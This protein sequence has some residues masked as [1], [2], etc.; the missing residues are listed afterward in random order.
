M[1]RSRVNPGSVAGVCMFW[2]ALID[3]EQGVLG[4]RP[5]GFSFTNVMLYG[6]HVQCSKV[7]RLTTQA[8][9]WP[10]SQ[11]FRDSRLSSRLGCGRFAVSCR[12]LIEMRSQTLSCQSL[13]SQHMRLTHVAWS[14]KGVL[15]F[16]L[17]LLGPIVIVCWCALPKC[18][19]AVGVCKRTLNF[20]VKMGSL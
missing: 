5:T 7:C 3:N 10:N 15:V 14:W 20:R 4:G 18:S 2:N 16:G 12:I 13:A 11:V 1:V 6:P 17:G 19:Y 9:G 8:S